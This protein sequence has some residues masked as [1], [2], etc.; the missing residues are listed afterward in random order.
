MVNIVFR[1]NIAHTSRCTPYTAVAANK[2]EEKVYYLMI[3]K[4]LNHNYVNL[5]FYEQLKVKSYTFNRLLRY[6]KLKKS[7][8][9]IG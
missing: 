8:F 4:V 3:F 9:F 6:R 7:L 5:L 2:R 1:F